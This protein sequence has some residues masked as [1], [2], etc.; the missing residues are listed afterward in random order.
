[1]RKCLR[2]QI[3]FHSDQRLNCLYCDT[4]LSDADF[5][6]IARGT[7]PKERIFQKEENI[8]HVRMEYL[9]G[10][11]FKNKTFSFLYNF[12]RNEL[13]LG[14]EFKRFFIQ[15]IDFTSVIKIPWIVI[16]IIDSIQ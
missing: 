15:P 16:N 9:V 2:C 4:R 7:S 10:S 3:I 8:K 6:E 14:K 1:M 5:G 12:S 11:Y 13:K